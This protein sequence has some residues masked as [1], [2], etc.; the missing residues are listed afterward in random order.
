MNESH[1]KSY[2]RGST[3]LENNRIKGSHLMWRGEIKLSNIALERVIFHPILMRYLNSSFFS[4]ECVDIHWINSLY[5]YYKFS[6]FIFHLIS[7]VGRPFPLSFFPNKQVYLFTSDVV[8]S[9]KRLT[10][11]KDWH[12]N[13]MLWKKPLLPAIRLF[14][15]TRGNNEKSQ[16]HLV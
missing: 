11:N 10:T 6:L 4:Y 8:L 1:K 12:I 7:I 5:Y 13:S 3:F 16:F 15:T 2:D 9:Y 14:Q